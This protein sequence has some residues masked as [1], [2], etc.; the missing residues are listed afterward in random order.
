ML[1]DVASAVPPEAALGMWPVFPQP[2]QL[3]V[4]GLVSK[5]TDFIQSFRII[6]KTY[7]TFVIDLHDDLEVWICLMQPFPPTV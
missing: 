1:S 7:L 3:L 6:V 5:D 2:E 4:L